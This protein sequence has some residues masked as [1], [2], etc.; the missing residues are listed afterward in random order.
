MNKTILKA[1]LIQLFV[2]V[3]QM[4]CCITHSFMISFYHLSSSS[5]VYRGIKPSVKHANCY[6]VWGW[7]IC[8]FAYITREYVQ[9]IHTIYIL[10]RPSAMR[11]ILATKILGLSAIYTVFINLLSI[12]NKYT[13]EKWVCLNW[14]LILRCP[15]FVKDS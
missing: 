5:L 3:G 11:C 8:G 14:I 10:I 1:S 13:L 2:L 9:D 7:F 4:H 12:K 15:A 6:S